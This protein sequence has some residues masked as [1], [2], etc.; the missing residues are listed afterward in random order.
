MLAYLPPDAIKI[1]P[2]AVWN[3][4]RLLTWPQLVAFATFPICATKQVRWRPHTPTRADAA[5]GHQL[6]PILEGGQGA[7]RIGPRGAVAKTPCLRSVRYVSPIRCTH[8]VCNVPP[9]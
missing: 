8:V 3:A 7:R 5:A 9:A 4:L 2:F 1:V 6:R